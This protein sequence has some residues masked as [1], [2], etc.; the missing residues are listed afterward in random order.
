MPRKGHG[1]ATGIFR[2][3]H[4][5]RAFIRT[6]GRLRSKRFTHDALAQAKQWRLEE[7]ARGRL[8]LV[9]SRGRP[10]PGT[11]AADAQEYLKAVK[12]MPS[13][14]DRTRDIDAWVKVFG[15]RHRESITAL[16]IKQQLE[17]WR[18]TKKYAAS[19]LNHRRSA[20][21]HLYRVLDMGRGLSNPVADI[22]KYA[23]DEHAALVH[24]P[25]VLEKVLGAIRPSK[26]KR[27]LS[28]FVWTGWPY[29]L[30]AKLTP[31]D[32]SRLDE[33]KPVVRVHPRRKGSGSS[34]RWLPVQPRAKAALEAL[35][36]PYDVQKLSRSSLHRA[37]RLACVRAKVTPCRPY[38]IRH[39]FG[40]LIAE[41]TKDARAVQELLMLSN[42]SQVARYAKAAGIV[43]AHAAI[44]AISESLVVTPRCNSKGRKSVGTRGKSRKVASTKTA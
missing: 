41:K 36:L 24:P 40:T 32:L 19:T 39:A 25:H 35:E 14:T 10:R 29:A 34:G 11:F 18:E 7:Q 22:P 28:V 21:R 44:D 31:A 27:V 38:D 37:W 20:L 13:I 26:A 6:R 5:L 1:L 9:P 15:H 30:I 12:G 8:G 33:D 16:D 3:A 2:D 4:G 43:R 23:E 17:T 42:P